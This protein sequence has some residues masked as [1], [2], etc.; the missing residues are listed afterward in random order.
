MK[1]VLIGLYNEIYDITKYLSKHPGEGIR[2]V[3]L[4]E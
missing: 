2:F 3:N 4:R 1:P